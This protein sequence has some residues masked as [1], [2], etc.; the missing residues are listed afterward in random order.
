MQAV[1]TPQ[2]S[3]DL[4]TEK[5]AHD[6]L[7]ETFGTALRFVARV[8]RADAT[9][10]VP[11]TNKDQLQLLRCSESD[12]ISVRIVPLDKK[13][14]FVLSLLTKSSQKQLVCRKSDPYVTLGATAG[15]GFFLHPILSRRAQRI[16]VCGTLTISRKTPCKF[17]TSSEA[18]IAVLSGLSGIALDATARFGRCSF[19]IPELISTSGKRSMVSFGQDLILSHRENQIGSLL[20]S[21]LTYK[22]IAI[23]LKMS[24]RTVEHYVERMKLRSGASTLQ[25]LM[26]CL[27]RETIPER[28]P[29]REFLS[30]LSDQ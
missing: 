19:S 24:K 18:L 3:P 25:G 28:S 20:A 1:L 4:L 17:T 14:G 10:A 13:V 30:T 11:S 26:S 29:L 16:L 12:V 23:A 15:G 9:I 8:C 21:D 22:Q 5:L 2:S 7:R 6:D 27:F